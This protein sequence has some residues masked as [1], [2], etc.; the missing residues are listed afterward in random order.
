M[1]CVEGIE[2]P[3]SQA[4]TLE[5]VVSAVLPMKYA[6]L[7]EKYADIRVLIDDVRLGYMRV[8]RMDAPGE[9]VWTLVWSFFGGTEYR[10]GG[11]GESVRNSSLYQ[12]LFTVNAIDGMVI[13]GEIGY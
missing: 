9:F 5:R 2:M 1:Y 12:S 13:N 10:E 8:M 7:A 4:L 3:S 6:K 11:D